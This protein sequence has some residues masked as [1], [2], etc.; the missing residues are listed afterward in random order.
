MKLI[1]SRKKVGVYNDYLDSTCKCYHVAFALIFLIYSILYD[2]LQVHPC[3]CKW[4]Y[5]IPFNGRVVFHCI[6]IPQRLYPFIGWQTFWLLPCL[7]Y[8]AVENIG[9]HVS[10]QIIVLPE[11][12]SRS[13]IAGSKEGMM[14]W[15][16]GNS[17]CKY[18]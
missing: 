13:G 7:G 15:E 4:H 14:G 9:V 11:Y 17:R 6:Y 2:D 10:S 16:F 8:S 3:S 5:F 12:M 1:G 18:Y